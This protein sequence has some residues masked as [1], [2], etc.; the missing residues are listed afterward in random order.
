MRSKT[1]HPVS[2]PGN[3][4]LRPDTSADAIPQ[5]PLLTPRPSLDPTALSSPPIRANRRMDSNDPD[6]IIP[7]PNVT[8]HA[9]ASALQT[10]V[11]TGHPVEHY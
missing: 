6:A 9:A 8:V 4:H 2:P 1:P 11:N 3:F 7:A 5:R 10:V